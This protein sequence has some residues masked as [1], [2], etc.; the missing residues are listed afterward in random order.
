[1]YA[2]PPVSTATQNDEET[3]ETE[4]SALTVDSTWSAGELH[5]LPAKVSAF[6]ASATAA[7]ND[8]DTHDTLAVPSWLEV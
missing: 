4:V 5:E 2:L 8:D 1:M 7:Q 6:P 3:H